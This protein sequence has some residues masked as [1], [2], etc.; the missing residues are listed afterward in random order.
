MKVVILAGGLGTRLS[1][2]TTKRPKPMVEIGNLPI[3]HHIM[4]I[5]SRH[6][7]NDFVICLGYKGYMIKEYF[8]NYSLHVSD[9]TVDLKN[10]TTIIHKNRAKNW[11][12]TLIDTGLNSMTGG[13]LKAVQDYVGDE[14]FCMTYGDGVA[15][16][17]ITK[18]LEFHK[19]HGK[20]ATVTSVVPPGRFGVLDIDGDKVTGFREKANSD[21]GFINGGFFVLEPDVLNYIKGPDTVWEKEP[22]ERLT[23]EN[24]MQAF[25]HQ[26][27]WQPMDTLREK[28]YLEDLISSGEAPWL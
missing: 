17:D 25:H 24:E 10:K 27:F 5:Y 1:E 11:R 2:E 18:L 4:D 12:V 13:R 15:D 8:V 7:L 6:G 26:G 28:K 14:T 20:K 19:S 21:I 22:M 9:I 3:L 16:V 23:S